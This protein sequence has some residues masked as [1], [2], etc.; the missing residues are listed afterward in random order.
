MC[1]LMPGS[2]RL[3]GFTAQAEALFQYHFTPNVRSR[4]SVFQDFYSSREHATNLGTMFR[5]PENPLLPNWRHIPVGYHGRSSSI[6]PSGTPLKRP[7]GQV[8]PKAP[9]YDPGASG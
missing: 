6:V 7:C 2:W 3:R 9:K 1:S 4:R 8:N 5:D